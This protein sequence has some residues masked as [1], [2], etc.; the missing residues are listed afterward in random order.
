[1]ANTGYILM[2]ESD[3]HD[4]EM[5][6]EYFNA[7]QIPAK[8]L[9]QSNEVFAFLTEAFANNEILPAII[10]LSMHSAP[11]NG[12]EVLKQIKS[13]KRFKHIPVIVLGEYTQPELVQKC[14]HEGANT[15]INKPFTNQLTDMKITSFLNYW[16]EV[17]ELA[18]DHKLQYV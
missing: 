17:A 14:Y 9:T 10:L 7:L 13:D 1:M 4:V 15:F 18:G 12:L 16:F 11:D 8:F 6:S 5:S 2:L 3:T